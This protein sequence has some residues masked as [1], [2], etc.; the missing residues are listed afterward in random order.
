MGESPRNDGIVTVYDPLLNITYWHW[1][2]QWWQNQCN[3][4]ECSTPEQF[5]PS[6]ME[7]ALSIMLEKL[8]GYDNVQKLCIIMLFEADF[9]NIISGWGEQL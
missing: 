3:F 6:L 4:G 9:N 7:K 5:N 2:I 8:A 1:K